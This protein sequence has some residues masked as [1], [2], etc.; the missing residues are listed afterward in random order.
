MTIVSKYQTPFTSISILN[1][2]DNGK[3][4]LAFSICDRI[5]TLYICMAFAFQ[6]IV[7]SLRQNPKT[8]QAEEYQK[9]NN[10]LTKVYQI[11]IV[12]KLSTHTHCTLAFSSLL[13]SQCK[14]MQIHLL[15]LNGKSK[16]EKVTKT[17][18]Y[19]QLV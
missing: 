8:K 13:S 11:H 16:R 10:K 9:K 14:F 15:L 19:F 3:S 7:Q 17:T 5:D 6:Q 18:N 12:L 1:A 4:Q 2:F